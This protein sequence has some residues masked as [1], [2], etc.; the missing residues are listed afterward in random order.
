[1]AFPRYAL[2][3][4]PEP[5]DPLWHF[6]SSAIGYDAVTGEPAPFFDHPLYRDESV[7][8]VTA[9]PRRYGFHATLKA[10]FGLAEDCDEAALL[11]AV[12]AFA[13]TRSAVPLSGLAVRTLGSFVALIPREL[14]TDLQRLAADC[15]E[16]FDGFRAPLSP[17]D[18]ERRQK[19]PLNPRQVEY[20]DRWGYPYVFE[21]FRFHMTLTGQL[22]DEAR[23]GRFAEI[24]SGLYAPIDLPIAIDGVAV[25]K[26]ESRDRSFRVLRRFPL[27]G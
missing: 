19:S 3:F 24:L 23:R 26:Q 15:V 10:P 20:L 16:F 4:M 25:F 17:Q 6:G 27:Q 8:A 21:E 7:W 2:Y 22:A 13:A 1:M 11:N 18:R 12:E 9:D 14:D 5:D